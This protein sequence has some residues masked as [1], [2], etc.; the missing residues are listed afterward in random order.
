[1]E[2]LSEE[3]QL[4][5]GLSEEQQPFSGLSA[6]VYKRNRTCAICDKKFRTMKQL[7]KHYNDCHED[8]QLQLENHIFNTDEE[9]LNWKKEEEI[10]TNSSFVDD[11]LSIDLLVNKLKKDVYN[12]VLVYKSIGN[13]LDYNPLIKEQDFILGV[14]TEA[15]LELLNIYGKNLV[16][17]DSTHGTNKYGFLLTTLMLNDE[18][19]EDLPVAILYSNRVC[20][21]VLELFFKGIKERLPSLKPKIFMSDDDPAF[22]NAWTKIFG[23]VETNL[24]CSWHVLHSWNRNLN[25]KINNSEL[26]NIKKDELRNLMREVDI[27]TFEHMFKCF[28]EKHRENDAIKG[29]I[30]YFLKFYGGRKEKWAYCYR[31]GCGVNTN[32]KLERW[33]RNLKYEGQGKI[34]QRLD[35]SLSLVLNAIDKKLVGRIISIERGKLTSKIAVIRERHSKS[36]IAMENYTVEQIEQMKWI[37]SKNVKNYINTYEINKSKKYN[38]LKIFL[39]TRISD[40]SGNSKNPGHSKNRSMP[41]LRKAVKRKDH[42]VP[43]VCLLF[44]VFL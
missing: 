44:P 25:N 17:I 38:L 35:R 34:M 8:F 10:K 41:T 7:I 9:F 18:N 43:V 28:V 3:Q 14:L 1:M 39:L 27:V 16:M 6:D 15:Q 36:V 5:S 26:K 37:V 2:V 24:L 31:V 23:R 20:C 29:F 21:Q 19:H 30:N 12:P 4:F 11:M 33:H 40:L 13:V 22:S 32:M 42:P